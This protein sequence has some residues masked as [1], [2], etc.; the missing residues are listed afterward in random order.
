MMR[1]MTRSGGTLSE[2]ARRCSV[3]QS[4]V[5]R[6][7]NNSTKGRFSVSPEVRERILHAARELNYRPSIAARN[8]TVSKTHLVAVLG[9][10]GIWSD[11]V[12]PVEE[13]VGAMAAALDHGRLRD[14]RAVPQ[15]APRRV[16]PSAASRGRRRR[17]AAASTS[18]TL[19]APGVVGHPLREPERACR[20]ARLGGVA[21]RRPGHGAWRCG[22]WSIWAT[23]ALPISITGRSMPIIPA[24]SSAAMRSRRPSKEM[25]FAVPELGLP[26][27]A[28]ATRLGFVLRTVRAKGDCRR[29]RHR[30][31]GLLAPGGPRT[32]ADCPR[33]GAVRPEG[34]QHRLL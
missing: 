12:G 17:S 23:A 8:L 13:A 26:L 22:T 20:R 27:L 30:R 19:D 10:A 15:P 16:R 32:A 31:P 34:L 1:T 14:L 29:R 21:R 33:P 5:S 28:G 18:K 24:S 11:R 3:S 9:V 6:V 7:L 25:E 4:T 2:V